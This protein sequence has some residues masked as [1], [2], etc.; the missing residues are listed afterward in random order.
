MS[1]RLARAAVA[2][3]CAWLAACQ[4][5]NS[6]QF[7]IP[8]ERRDA[9]VA[10]VERVAQAHGMRDC[11]PGSD[12]VGA[13]GCF[14]SGDTS[15]TFLGVR[16]VDNRLVVDLGFRSAGIGGDLFHAMADELRAGLR[17]ACGAA[18]VRESPGQQIPIEH[19]ASPRGPDAGAQAAGV[20]P[21]PVT[22]RA[23]LA[24][25]PSRASDGALHS[26]R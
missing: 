10:E 15:F 17:Q 22:A 19:G 18:A 4:T 6:L 5:F 8:A 23:T 24:S 26:V 11:M 2:A 7:V 14:L 16:Q 25:A 3:L 13:F 9:V 12:V 21:A 20:Q 1:R